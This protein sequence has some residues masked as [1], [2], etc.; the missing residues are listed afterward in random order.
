MKGWPD[1]S[2]GGM[3]LSPP[4][5]DISGRLSNRIRGAVCSWP[6]KA[7]CNAWIGLDLGNHSKEEVAHVYCWLW[8]AADPIIRSESSDPPTARQW[9]VNFTLTHSILVQC[10]CMH[11]SHRRFWPI[12]SKKRLRKDASKGP[13]LMRNGLSI[14]GIPCKKFLGVSLPTLTTFQYA[15]N[16]FVELDFVIETV[17]LMD[18]QQLRFPRVISRL[19][20]P[21]AL[22]MF[23]TGRYGPLFKVTQSKH[24]K[25]DEDIFENS[26][27]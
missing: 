6:A 12:S 8:A 7:S 19:D 5:K 20:N 3:I 27:K 1:S 2:K 10:S 13:K 25:P 4:P 17:D 16:T 21:I 18:Q 22:W 23:S 26:C 9:Q 11:I 24:C 15:K 14:R